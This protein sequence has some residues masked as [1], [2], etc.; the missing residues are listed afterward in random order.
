MPLSTVT[1]PI[2]SSFPSASAPSDPYDHEISLQDTTETSRDQSG[3][4]AR[5]GG[6]S[7]ELVRATTEQHSRRGTLL[8]KTAIKDQYTRRKYAR[9]QEDRYAEEEEDKELEAGNVS[10]KAAPLKSS[11]SE[12]VKRHLDARRGRLL[13]RLHIRSKRAARVKEKESATDILYENQRGLFLF[14]YPLYSSRSL[15]NFDPSPWTNAEF[16]DSPVDIRNAQVP[17]PAWVWE[18]KRWYVDMTDDVD[19]EGWQYSLSFG[20]RFSWHGTHPWF[21]S[22]VRRRRWLRKRVK[23]APHHATENNAHKLT[24]DYFTIHSAPRETS[25][26][27]SAERSGAG[28]RSSFHGSR[29]VSP[30]D[31]E[32]EE[33]EITN[34]ASLLKEMKKTTIDRKKMDAVRNF[35]SAGGDEVAFLPEAVPEVLGLF[36]YQTSRRQMLSVVEDA[37]HRAEGAADGGSKDKAQS[38]EEDGKGKA[39]S[40]PTASSQ[41]RLD[42][43]R[44]SIDAVHQNIRHVEYYSD[45]RAMEKQFHAHEEGHSGSASD[46]DASSS[47]LLDPKSSS[48]SKAKTNQSNNEG[49]AEHNKE[50]RRPADATDSSDNQQRLQERQRAPHSRLRR[51]DINEEVSRVEIRGI[52]QSAGVDVEP[53]IL[54]PLGFMQEEEGGEDR[55]AG[56]KEVEGGKEGG[57][58][59][60]AGRVEAAVD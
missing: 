4:P 37:L 28:N 34:V 19:E 8:S 50:N 45:V 24:Q 15:L 59:D 14:G 17:D 11:K 39:A 33:E 32:S 23:I 9:F 36:M 49:T 40:S 26:S 51:L 12:A 7:T 57:R 10:K 18:W 21:H 20:R 29:F 38:Q 58:D 30:D 6:P 53:G 47:T 1:S 31:S 44:K 5:S 52:P 35:V 54:R 27:S 60:D 56:G 13:E 22:A 3:S 16:Q 42:G 43:L 25:R 41:L 2:R 55:K 48:S 46:L